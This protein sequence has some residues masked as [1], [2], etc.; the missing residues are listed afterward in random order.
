[1][2][3]A[4]IDFMAQMGYGYE[5][6][7]QSGISFAVIGVECTYKAMVRFGDEVEVRCTIT[8]YTPARMTVHYTISDA[9]SGFLRAEGETRH[10]FVNREGR[11]VR[12]RK[13]LPDLYEKFLPLVQ[14]GE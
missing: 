13:A 1:M 10:C 9:Q 8:A 11:P 6:V 3:E 14:T 12:L 7:E 4:R 2:E 5:R